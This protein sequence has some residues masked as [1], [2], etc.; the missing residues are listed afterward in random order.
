VRFL[1]RKLSSDWTR[2]PAS[3]AATL[4]FRIPLE[5]VAAHVP[6]GLSPWTDDEGLGMIEIGYVRFFRQVRGRIQILPPSEEVAFG[7]RVERKRGLGMAFLAVNVA[8]DNEQFLSRAE[9]DAFATYPSTIRFDA[10]LDAGVIS[11]ADARGP[12]CTLRYRVDA[13]VTMPGL[14]GDTE[15]WSNRDDVLLRRRFG[16]QGV[17]KAVPVPV[18]A[19]TLCEHPF[20]AGI[21]VTK[22][23]PLATQ[24]L[25]SRRLAAG[26]AQWFETPRPHV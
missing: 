8:A 9:R 21:D 25:I 17:A 3:H 2:W 14:P 5:H 19:S 16:W 11:A 10:D 22:A 18:V 6:R 26:A 13:S 12:I 15:V 1:L 24:A 20:F 7:V 23:E 4:F